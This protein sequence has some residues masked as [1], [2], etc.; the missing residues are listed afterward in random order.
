MGFNPRLA[1]Q[2]YRK[3]LY[4]VKTRFAAAALPGVKTPG[5]FKLNSLSSKV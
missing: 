5:Y 1:T 3:P 2:P 4:R